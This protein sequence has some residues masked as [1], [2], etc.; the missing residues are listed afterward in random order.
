MILPQKQA[1]AVASGR[2]V[3]HRI[4][5]GRMTK[6]PK[7]GA[8]FKVAYWTRGEDGKRRTET[9]CWVEITREPEVVGL[10]ALDRAQAHTEGYAGVRGPL[11]FQRAYIEAHDRTWLAK[12]EHEGDGSVTDEQVSARFRW[13]HVDTPVHLLTWRL[14]EEPDEYMAQ[15]GGSTHSPSRSIDGDAPMPPAE[16]VDRLAKAAE[17]R[18]AEMRASFQR[19]LE[20]ERARRK[21]QSPRTLKRAERGRSLRR[22]A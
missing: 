16:Y 10:T 5:V 12:R 14:C 20:T 22:A 6:G 9:A 3:T 19:D 21:A 4:P 7:A 15:V 1:E 17:A 11:A 13:F 18:N 2:K 8:R